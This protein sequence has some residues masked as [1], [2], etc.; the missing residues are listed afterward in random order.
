MLISVLVVVGTFDALLLLAQW[1][2]AK[3]GRRQ[4]ARAAWGLAV[5]RAESARRRAEVER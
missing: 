2:A 1:G 3:E 5:Y 4:E